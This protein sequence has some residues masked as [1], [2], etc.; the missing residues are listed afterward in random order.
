LIFKYYDIFLDIKKWNKKLFFSETKFTS[1]RDQKKRYFYFSSFDID[2]INGVSIFSVVIV[3]R[4]CQ[5]A[6]GVER[7]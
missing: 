5:T 1:S 2:I 3:N 6:S 7:V 4:C